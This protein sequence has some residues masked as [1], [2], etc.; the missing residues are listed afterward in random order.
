MKIIKVD[1][2]NL[3]LSEGALL[4]PEFAKIYTTYDKEKVIPAL[5]FIY[6]YADYNSPYK[7]YAEDLRI[8]ELEKDLHLTYDED[9]KNAVEKYKDLSYTFT[10]KY[11]DSALRAAHKNMGYWD[12]VDYSEKD[13]KGNFVYSI[14]EV[15]RSLGDCLKAVTAIESLKEKIKNEQIGNNKIRGG[16]DVSDFEK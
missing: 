12:N 10:M 4:V 3:E 1:G 8:K 7:E 11:C 15:Q 13:V 6:L 5:K 16:G 14:T 2:N 9:L